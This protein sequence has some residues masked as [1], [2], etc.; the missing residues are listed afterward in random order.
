[1][2][3]ITLTKHHGLG[4][5]FLISVAPTVDIGAGEAVAWCDRR[6][7]IGADGLIVAHPHGTEPDTWV[8]TMWNADGSRPEI[9]GNGLRC[10][11]QALVLH[12]DHGQPVRPFLV[13]TD[14]GF[15]RVEVRPDRTSP[16]DQVRVEMGA[17]AAGV[18]R[19]T[20]WAD[21]GLDVVDQLGVDIGNPHL[22][23]RTDKLG[24]ID[25]AAIGPAVEASYPG[26]I[27]VELI[28]VTDR[29]GI[30]LRVWERGAGITEACG[31]GACAATWAANRWGL[32]DETVGVTMPG[33]TAT[34]ELI[35]GAVVLTGPATF[36]AVI[37]I[38][39]R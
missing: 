17:P 8:M 13:R 6:R 30:D 35:D 5:D 15:R 12:H 36:V 31:S 23:A 34:V 38:E 4:N 24:E 32:V 25:L 20:G 14:A 29:A 18:A 7:G 16:T 27:N 26:G 28:T 11:G 33:G 19:F 9:S 3:T 10:L 37:E 1:L 22:V 39:P 21:L 2:S